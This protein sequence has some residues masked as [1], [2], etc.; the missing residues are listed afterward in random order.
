MHRAA[1]SVRIFESE[2]AHGSTL[3]HAS[4]YLSMLLSGY[5]LGKRLGVWSQSTLEANCKSSLR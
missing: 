3:G 2:S 1:L 5:C 4:S